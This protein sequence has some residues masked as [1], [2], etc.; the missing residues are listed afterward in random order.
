MR[1]SGYSRSVPTDGSVDSRLHV[2]ALALQY[3]QQPVHILISIDSI[4]LPVA[5]TSDIANKLQAELQIAREQ[6]VFCNTHTHSGPH[7]FEYYVFGFM[8][9]Y[10]ES[11]GRIANDYRNRLRDWIVQAAKQ[12]VAGLR[13][14]SVS[15]TQGTVGFA[16]H[17]GLKLKDTD[18]DFVP[19]LSGP[20]DH[21]L[22]LLCLK[23]EDNQIVALVFN[24]A[25]HCTTLDS[26]YNKINSDWAGAATDQ[27]ELDF[28]GSVA[29]CTIGCGGDC[30][31]EPR[32]SL[33]LINQHARSIATEVKRLVQKPMTM[34]GQP[35]ASRYEHADLAF[36]LPTVSQLKARQSPGKF[37]LL[38][39]SHAYRMLEL[40][41]RGGKLPATYHAPIQTWNF[42]N[43]LTMVFLSGEVVVDYALRLKKE[44]ADPNLWVTAY[45]NDV[46]GFI[47]SERMRPERGN[48]YRESPEYFNQP[49]PWA[50]GTED[51]LINRV[52]ELIAHT[53]DSAPQ[54]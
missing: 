49:G 33:Q 34:V 54:P 16:A 4:G 47:D 52:K 2:R 26:E 22:P 18:P 7:L 32:G 13:P 28:P 10:S 53:R 43:Q 46:F 48:Q 44:L 25:C 27:L 40:L 8:M 17:R 45:A 30:D 50:S 20:V 35:I 3:H 15:H 42:G 36:E 38:S 9:G 21:A 12:A 51:R 39:G 37:F 31:P 23:N 14:A 41:K 24:Y 5:M 1:L 11:D 19:D 6:I 29:L